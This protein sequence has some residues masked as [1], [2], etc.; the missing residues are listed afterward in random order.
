VPSPGADPTTGNIFPVGQSHDQGIIYIYH[1][2]IG[3]NGDN[4]GLKMV[5]TLNAATLTPTEVT[6]MSAIPAL[7]S[8]LQTN[9]ATTNVTLSDTDLANLNNV[10]APYPIT[11]MNNGKKAITGD[12]PAA[13]YPKTTANYTWVPVLP[14]VKTFCRYLVILGVCMATIWM[15]MASYGMVLGMPYAGSRVLGTAMGLMMLL[16]AFTIWKIVQM[17]TYNGNTNA[18]ATVVYGQ[19][20]E[21]Q[22]TAVPDLPGVPTTPQFS[23]RDGLPVQPLIGK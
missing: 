3:P 1:Q 13:G 10:L 2:Q 4:R 12:H 9:Q 18:P 7:N 5:M 23:A 21:V 11:T 6:A 22:P 17:N 14:T 16:S 20:N 19:D 8:V 15:A